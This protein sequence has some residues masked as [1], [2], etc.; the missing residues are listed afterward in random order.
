MEQITMEIWVINDIIKI[1]SL[2][3]LDLVSAVKWAELGNT[4]VSNASIK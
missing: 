4:R 3:I 2:N 1:Y